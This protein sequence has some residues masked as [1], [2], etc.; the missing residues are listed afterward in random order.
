[1][2]SE[3]TWNS[4][5]YDVSGGSVLGLE[6]LRW[7]G[8]GRVAVVCLRGLLGEQEVDTARRQAHGLPDPGPVTDRAVD[9]PSRVRAA[10]RRTFGLATL[11]PASGPDGEA[12]IRLH[13]DGAR[14]PLHHDRLTRDA[15]GTACRLSCVVSLQEC[16]W[17]G[18]LVTYRKPWEPSDERW[19]VPDGPGYRGE[20]VAAAPRHVF[21]PRTRD[22]YLINPAYY[23][24]TEKTHGATRT[25]LGFFIGFTDDTLD[26][27]VTW[28]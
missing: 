13:S 20:V 22:V 4:A 1:M 16:D 28:G 8:T 6:P 21:R 23:H 26:H 2:Q 3:A 9:L 15:T 14:D 27:A 10:L 25:T 24:E 18:E 17:G 5:T 7:L 11:D 12:V 19:R